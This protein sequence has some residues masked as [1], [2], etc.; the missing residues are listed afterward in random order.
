MPKNSLGK[1]GHEKAPHAEGREETMTFNDMLKLPLSKDNPTTT[2]QAI[3]AVLNEAYR[4][5]LYKGKSCK[6]GYEVM[7]FRCPD[8]EIQEEE[9]FDHIAWENTNFGVM[10]TPENIKTFREFAHLWCRT[11]FLNQSR[12]F[13]SL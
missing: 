5:G 7:V 12:D 10:E 1:F 13:D 11:C 8:H 9:I 3:R 2:G 6:I 4:D